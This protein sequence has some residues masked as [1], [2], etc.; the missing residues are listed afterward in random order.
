MSKHEAFHI[1]LG[2]TVCTT[3]SELARH[4]GDDKIV[5]E[6]A[7]TDKLEEIDLLATAKNAGFRLFIIDHE[8]HLLPVEQTSE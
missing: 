7:H 6:T 1:H 8:A 4:I 5:F 3:V 2:D